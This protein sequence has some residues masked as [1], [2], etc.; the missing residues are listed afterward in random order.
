MQ[1]QFFSPRRLIGALISVAFVT[2]LLALPQA[3][4]TAP[5]NLTLAPPPNWAVSEAVGQASAEQRNE[6]RNGAVYLLSDQQVRVSGNAVERYFHH[7]YQVVAQPGIEHVSQLEFEFDPSYQRLA[8]H[9][10]Q[11]K[12][13][14][15]TIN[16]LKAHEIRLLPKEDELE[17]RLF[18]GA[19]TALVILNDVRVGDVV[20]YDY[21]VNGANPILGGR[22]VDVNYLAEA[23]PVARLR[24]RLLWPSARA[25]QHQLRELELKPVV[26]P[27]GE[28]TEYTWE[29][30]NAP[31]PELEPDGSTPPEGVPEL[32]LSEFKNWAEVA[33]WAAPLYRATASP[34]L[35]RQVESWR[36]ATAE[37]EGQILAAV[38]FVQDEIR[39]LGIEQGTHSHQP[40]A[41]AQVL[42]RR[43]GDCKD[44]AL[45]LATALN[46]LG[47]EAHPALVN[48][49]LTG[50]LPELLPSP[51]SFDH[52]ITQ[53]K[54]QGKTYWFDATISLQ[55]GGLAQH[56][57]PEFGHA[58]VIGAEATRLE[59]IPL[60][61]PA[62]PLK[63]IKE[64]YTVNGDD[65]TA[66]LEV[67]TTYRGIDADA[68]RDYVAKQPLNDL[69]KERLQ[70]LRQRD[71]SASADGKPQV[72]DDPAAN[73]I[74]VTER[75]RIA[76]FWRD[77]VRNLVADRI[78]QELPS[79]KAEA[80][81]AMRLSYPLDVEHQIEIRTPA[82]LSL[83]EEE[84]RIANEALQFDYRREQHGRTLKLTHR[85]RTLRPYV[86]AAA[87]A[88]LANDL[89]RIEDFSNLRLTNQ[90]SV[91]GGWPRGWLLL[92]ALL[93]LLVPFVVF[94]S[95]KTLRAK[96]RQT[97]R[98]ALTLPG[99][100]PSIPMQ[101][102]GETDLAERLL[103]LRCECGSGYQAPL[104]G[105]ERA[106]MFYDG[107]RL[108]L[109]QLSCFTCE[110][111]RDVYCDLAAAGRA[112]T[113]A[114]VLEGTSCA[115]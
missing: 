25:L 98:A 16:A 63:L 67:V 56:C 3:S 9:R 99:S 79:S 55:R 91:T 59:E 110:R 27:L 51:F 105:W 34:A 58:L 65:H 62:K 21:S 66:T 93:L 26:K 45:L 106:G 2:L 96:R 82:A 50:R 10:I 103:A 4:Q 53:V 100:A 80:Q 77:G 41:P 87:A 94:L 40:H 49:N 19:L 104:K 18:N 73:L 32:H 70:N 115:D 31:A 86:K 13:G 84:G 44:K 92:G 69:A 29:R 36:Q 83:K 112:A 48:T 20:E 113:S 109:V 7:L 74:V 52:V 75:Y 57:N 8:I 85:L 6:A 71:R 97:T 61:L 68:M 30:A 1:Y 88:R 37:P 111:G 101:L 14:A 81:H 89:E 23:E 5:S 46:A 76:R 12:R 102:S 33:A 15:Q 60:A 11:I 95:Y 54:T 39:Y 38:R 43:Y 78:I 90:S 114:G 22:F 107:R 28:L 17:Q 64:L 24:Y 108:E 72:K 47:Y 35:L 42:E